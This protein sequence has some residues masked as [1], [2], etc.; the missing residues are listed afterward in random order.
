MIDSTGTMAGIDGITEE[1]PRLRDFQKT[2]LADEFLY[3]WVPG[4]DQVIFPEGAAKRIRAGSDLI[5][6]IHYAP[7]AKADQD[8]SEVRLYFAR[9]PVKQV[10][11]TLTLTENSITN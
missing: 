8:Q 10:V 6:N 1:D 7:S 2:P 4:N 11:K 5:L 9:K 3:G